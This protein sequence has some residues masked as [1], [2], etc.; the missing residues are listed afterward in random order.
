M[1]DRFKV[2]Y[3]T[4]Q[5]LLSNKQ[6][7]LATV[8]VEELGIMHPP[9]EDESS[10]FYIKLRDLMVSLR[11]PGAEVWACE[12]SPD[13]FCHNDGGGVVCKHCGG[14]LERW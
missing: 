3:N 13:G 8:L 7:G 12:K 6:L 2:I 10:E 4:A 1:R 9:K 5:A 11:P 14:F